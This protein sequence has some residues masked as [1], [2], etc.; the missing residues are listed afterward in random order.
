MY[1]YGFVSNEND[2]FK[3][4]IFFCD[5]AKYNKPIYVGSQ[6]GWRDGGRIKEKKKIYPPF[7]VEKIRQGDPYTLA[8]YDIE[9]SEY[10]DL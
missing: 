8:I 10:E 3:G 7:N 2:E 9:C 1:S 5:L 6:Y 4:T